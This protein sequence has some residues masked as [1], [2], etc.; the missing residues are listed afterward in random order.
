MHQIGNRSPLARVRR[1]VLAAG[2][3]ATGAA[4]FAA[5]GAAAHGAEPYVPAP[6][7]ATPG[8]KPRPYRHF[9]FTQPSPFGVI[10]TYQQGNRVKHVYT[11][12]GFKDHIPEPAFLFY[13]DPWSRYTQGP[14]Y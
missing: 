4:C 14:G 10:T 12:P 2:V 11:Y 7:L 9:D 8:Q 5:G 13:G 1:A 3:L 6:R